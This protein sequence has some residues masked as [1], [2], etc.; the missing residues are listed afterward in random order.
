MAALCLPIVLIATWGLKRLTRP[1][2]LILLGV[3][4]AWT[5]MA[6]PFIINAMTSYWEYFKAGRPDSSRVRDTLQRIALF[7]WQEAPIWGHGV[8]EPG[9]KIVEGMPIGTHH[10]IFSLLFVKGIVGVIAFV[11]P[12][13]CSFVA[14]VAK[15]QKN[16]T[17]SVGLSIILVLGISAFG[18][19]LEILAY[20]FWP[21]LVALGIAFRASVTESSR[22]RLS[23]PATPYLYS[24]AIR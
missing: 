4:T 7:R 20:I 1:T 21:G 6:A 18:D 3:G 15:A 2:S 8:V 19:N 5:S 22:D 17:A 13:L 24:R 11:V 16:E 12:V 23:W 9:P 10:T 14:L